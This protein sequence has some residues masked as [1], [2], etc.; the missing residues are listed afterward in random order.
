MSLYKRCACPDPDACRAHPWY[1]KFKYQGATIRESTEQISKAKAALVEIKRHAA[2]ID[3]GTGI[4]KAPAPRLSVH[5]ARYL[6]HAIGHHPATAS[7]K[8]A[9]ILPT[10][11]AVI[12]DKRLDAITPFDIDRWRSARLKV[13]SKGRPLSRSTVNR[14]LNV[15]RGL[16]TRAVEWQLLEASP[17]EGIAPWKVDGTRVRTLTLAERGI[18]LTQ[19]DPLHAMLCRVTLEA[20]LR[21]SEVLLLRREDLGAAS[22]QRRLKGGRVSTIPVTPALV[23]DLRAWLKTPEQVHVFGDPPPD[24]N[25]VSSQLTRDARAHGLR[26]ISHHTMRHTGVTD[27][28]ADGIS[29]IAIQ[30]YAGWTSLRMLERYGHLR[31]AELQRAT[32]G[33]AAR[34]TA[35]IAE[36][37][38][39]ADPPAA[40]AEAAR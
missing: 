40:G 12:G 21:L 28:L 14:E 30:E 36:A 19:L 26:G 17:L 33:T 27:M 25:A 15:I 11:Q 22:I 39:A 34:N 38:A 29:P 31:D 10:L 3:R 2:V 6:E 7:T 13:I 37:A 18:V 8:D 23:A 1:L 24:P 32:I 9:R 35:A 5:V 20:L 16:F 4:A